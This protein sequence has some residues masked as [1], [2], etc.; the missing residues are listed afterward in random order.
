MEKIVDVRNKKDGTQEF[1][2]HWKNWAAE[3]DTWEPEK[4]LQC[5]DLIDRFFNRVE[6]L[7]DVDARELREVRKHTERFTLQTSEFGRRLSKR[8][9]QKQ[10]VAY[11]DAVISDD[12]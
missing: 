8:N 10:R 5:K 11:H 3:Y 12:E 4:H 9:T 7:K 1:L 6:K 2:V